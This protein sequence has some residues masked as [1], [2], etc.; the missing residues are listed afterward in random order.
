MKLRE[1]VEQALQGRGY[2]GLYLPTN[3]DTCA[4]SLHDD[5]ICACD[6]P[7]LDECLAGIMSERPADD[8]QEYYIKEGCHGSL[9]QRLVTDVLRII[10]GCKWQEASSEGRVETGARKRHCNDLQKIRRAVLLLVS[11]KVVTASS[12]SSEAEAQGT[13]E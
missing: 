12:L 2:D 13:G 10:D 9:Q 11:D 4:C 1:L 7:N 3:S 5:S 8:E 6:N